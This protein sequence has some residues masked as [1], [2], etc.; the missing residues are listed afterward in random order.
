MALFRCCAAGDAMVFRRTTDYD[1][2]ETIRNY[3][4]Q[5]D[6]RFLNLET[7]VHR[8]ET[9]GSA[10][11]GGSW[12]CCEPEVMQDMHKYGFNIL[13]TAN[14]HSHDYGIEGLMLT[15]KYIREAGFQ[16][17]GTGETLAEASDP[18]YLDTPAAR[19][20]LIAGSIT[21][22]PYMRAGEQTRLMRGRPGLNTIGFGTRYTVT[23]E[24]FDMLRQIVSG[25]AIN[26]ADDIA[27]Q[28]GYLPALPENEL[29]FGKYTF[30]RSDTCGKQSYV[31]PADMERTEKAIR[32][33]RFFSDYVIISIHSHEI[34]KT[35]KEE[36]DEALEIFSKRCIDAGADAVIGTGPHLMRPI[37]IYK[38]KPIFYC[39]G[40]FIL[41]NETMRIVPDEM[42]K[43]QG[44]SG[45]DSMRDMY[46]RRSEHGRKGL[47]YTRS[48]FESFIPYWEAE[49][50]KLKK[51]DLLPIELGFGQ[52]Q[53][54]GGV[55]R[56]AFDKGI[57]ERLRDM[58][59]PYGTKIEIDGKGIG[60]I[61]L[62]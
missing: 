19:Y 7:T 2:L 20:S 29:A 37:E 50:G 42:F 44:L 22:S 17:A 32:E 13:S 61:R 24:Q 21:F 45:N 30:I 9:Y 4:G 35:D 25:T 53:S 15:L 33:A 59:R 57:L 48:M 34:R 39:L 41:E 6:F 11:S 46:D 18:V 28:E 51:I 3:I 10:L 58:S 26:G 23:P 16:A 14:N 31:E 62:A 38:G 52:P 12:F 43:K 56:P 54:I 1:G 60:H 49:D 27:R 55:P 36:P 40:D 8:F 47:Y 5:A